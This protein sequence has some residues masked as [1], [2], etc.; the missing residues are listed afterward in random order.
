LSLFIET[1]GLAIPSCD[2][3]VGKL[4]NGMDR[5]YEINFAVSTER[6]PPIPTIKFELSFLTFFSILLIDLI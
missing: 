6:P 1:N 5:L 3:A 4:T 2:A